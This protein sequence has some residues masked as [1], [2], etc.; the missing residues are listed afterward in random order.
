[1]NVQDIKNRL[2]EFASP[3]LAFDYDNVGL[4]F[5]NLLSEVKGI[6]VCLDCTME[7]LKK[8]KSENCNLIISHHPV[9][10]S[11]LKHIDTTN[12]VGKIVEFALKNDMSLLSY[13]TN[14]DC[15]ENGLNSYLSKLYKGKILDRFDGG[16]LF[17]IQKTTLENFA[18]NTKNILDEKSLRIVGNPQKTIDKVFVVCGAGGRDENAYIFAK[19]NADVFLTA[20][21][22]HN[23]M[24]SCQADDFALVEASHFK[25]EVIVTKLL[26]EVLEKSFPKLNIILQQS[27]PFWTL[28][29]I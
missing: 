26:Q 27:C 20:E 10:F 4:M 5:G 15:A 16:V 25:T 3:D 12:E 8:A 17:E 14:L 9:I 1:M 23:I 19:Q 13:H 6:V 21:I 18:K 28:E 11:P 24:I 7:T 22:K 2:D 29:E